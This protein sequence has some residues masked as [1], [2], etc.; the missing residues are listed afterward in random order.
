MEVNYPIVF[1]SLVLDFSLTCSADLV[2]LSAVVG[3]SLGAL[4]LSHTPQYKD[5]QSSVSAIGYS[6]FIPVFFV[7]IGL[8]MTFASFIKEI[9]FII[10]MNILAV[11][12]KL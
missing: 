9:W 1:A 7:N 6:I 4:L 8:S 12:S 11:L 3:A 2:T 10:V 5:V